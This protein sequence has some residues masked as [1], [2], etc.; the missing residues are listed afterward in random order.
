MK[1]KR[2]FLSWVLAFCLTLICFSIAD[3]TASAATEVPY[4]FSGETYRIRNVGSGKYLNVDDGDDSDGINVFQKTGNSSIDQDFTIR[5]IS[6]ENCY[7]IYPAC[8][9]EG[10]NRVLDIS[11]NG[12]P[13]TSSCNV[14]IWSEND[15]PAQ[16]LQIVSTGTAG[17]Y[18]IQPISNTSF[19]LT[20]NGD[21]D[22][23]GS[24]TSIDDAGNVV[25]KS[26]QSNSAYQ[27][28]ELISKNALPGSG[29]FHIRNKY[30]N[31]VLA[32]GGNQIIQKKQVEYCYTK[33][34]VYP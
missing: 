18:Y 12:S 17:Q 33:V 31:M 3:F 7:K 25:I 29:Y 23:D 8:S 19:Y 9:D 16:Q 5:W 34:G 30:S 10:N 20:A 21:A 15:P 11:R 22:G 2:K 27:K 1:K 14:Q 4:I 13:I 28:W 24:D 6:T 26:A 32:R